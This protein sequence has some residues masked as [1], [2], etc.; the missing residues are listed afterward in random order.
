MFGVLKTKT[1]LFGLLLASPPM[2]AWWFH[3]RDTR[4]HEPLS[5]SATPASVSHVPQQS[6]RIPVEVVTPGRGTQTVY[7]NMPV[8]SVPEPGLLPLGVVSSLL[9]LRRK[10]RAGK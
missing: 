1:L 8:Q 6:A 10:R 5:A 7:V 9:L 4:V 3:T 2:G